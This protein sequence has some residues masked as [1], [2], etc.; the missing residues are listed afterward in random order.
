M[1][2]LETSVASYAGNVQSVAESITSATG[3][4]SLNDAVLVSLQTLA[5][6][7][8]SLAQGV[9][10]VSSEVI[11]IAPLVGLS[12]LESSLYSMLSLSSDIGTMAD[13]ILEMADNILVMADNIGLMADRILATEIIQSSNL[14]LVVQAS[15]E[16]QKNTLTLFSL[17]L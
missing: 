13:R 9:M 8:A 5:T 15:L 11:L 2:D 7:S 6:V 17:F 10:T 4:T 16:T 12:A 3:T 1:A 14:D